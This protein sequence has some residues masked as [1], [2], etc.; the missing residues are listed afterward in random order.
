MTALTMTPTALIIT[1]TIL[2]LMPITGVQYIKENAVKA[3]KC[4]KAEK[5]EDLIFTDEA[6]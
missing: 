5:K 6:S 2:R 1:L 4:K 3:V